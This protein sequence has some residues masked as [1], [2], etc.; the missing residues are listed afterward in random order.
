MKQIT[1]CQFIYQQ[2]EKSGSNTG[3]GGGE[4]RI[5]SALGSFFGKSTVGNQDLAGSLVSEERSILA[6]AGYASVSAMCA[7]KTH[8]AIG[9]QNG[10]LI[11]LDTA[12]SPESGQLLVYQN[13]NFG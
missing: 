2:S 11:L 3:V 8:L 5:L 12:N 1:N 6:R 4:N 13:K 9:F 10:V 7:S